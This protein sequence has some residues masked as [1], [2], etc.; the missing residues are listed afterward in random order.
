MRPTITPFPSG[1]RLAAPLL[2][3]VLLGAL[4]VAGCGSESTAPAITE[5]DGQALFERR[6][7]GN[8]AGCVTCHSRAEGVVLVGP[9]LHD[10]EAAAA[11]AGYPDARAYVRESIVEPG[12]YTVPGFEDARAM[13]EVFGELL[14][15]E[16]I[17]AIIDHLLE[18]PS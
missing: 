6:A 4:T 18:V 1:R 12:A 2:L 3:V 13:P 9:S 7:L 16:Q 11:A 10:V 15:D 17:E 5:R 8:Q 14:D